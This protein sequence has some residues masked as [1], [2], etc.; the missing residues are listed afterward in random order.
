MSW[1]EWLAFGFVQ[2]ALLAGSFIAVL[3]AVL[4]VFLV[5]RRLS[6]IG[7]GLAHAT[8]GSAAL[9]LWLQWNPLYVSIPLVMVS[10]LGILKLAERTRIYG[11]AAI[12]VVSAVGIAGGVLIAGLAGGFNV[13]LFSFLFGSILTIGPLEVAVS[14]VLSAVVVLAVSLFYQELLS[15]TFD[16]ESARASG[17]R[18]DRINRI[19]GLLTAVAVVLSM[20]VVGILLISA[21]L[22]LPAV[23]AL[24]LTGSF[25]ATM[26]AAA[27]IAV[28]SVLT[29]IFFSFALD[30]PSGATI[31]LINVLFLVVG[32]AIRRGTGGRGKKA[33]L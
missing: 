22:I 2:R 7:D 14:V 17:I 15:V 21:L 20:K 28:L 3:C 18:V 27:A 25:R 30:L 13:D 6:L 1:T 11:D 4:G 31:V 10:A 23:T 12:G 29:G 16:E 5:L 9:A 19:F 33:A 24:Q 32:L 26:A 8:F